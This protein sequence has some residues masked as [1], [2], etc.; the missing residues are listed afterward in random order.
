MSDDIQAERGRLSQAEL[1][2]RLSRDISATEMVTVYWSERIDQH[3]H[4]IYC[5]MIPS[6]RVAESL[7]DPCWDLMHGDGLPG[8]TEYTG[9]KGE[10]CVEYLRFGD[11]HVE[12]LVID[13]EF[14]GI[15]PDYVELSEEFRLFHK[16]Y[17]D[18]KLDQ[19]IKIEDDGSETLVATIEPKRV[20]VR[21]KELRQFL[22]IKEMHLVIQF[23]CREHSIHTLEELGLEAKSEDHFEPTR[24][25]G[26]SYGSFYG[27]GGEHKSFSRLLGKRLIPPLPKEKSGFW[28]FAEPETKEHEHFII[29]V[30]ANGDDVTH[31]SDPD[32]LSNYFGANPGEPHY[33]TAVHFRKS[34]LDKYYQ[35]AGKYTVG[36]SVLWCGRLWS[37][38][39]DNHHDDRVC[40]WLGDL[41]RDLPHSEQLHWRS[42]NIPPVGG[43]SEVYFRRQILAQFTDSTQPEHVFQ[44]RYESLAA[45]C[46]KHSG[47]RLLLPLAAEDQHYLHGIRV[48]ATDEQKDFDDLI[49]GLAK[50]LVD[51]LN[52]AKLSELIA[53]DAAK[54]LRGSIAKLEAA[55]TACGVTD[56]GE[57][58]KFLRNLQNLRSTGSAHRKGSNYQTIAAQ[59]G[60]DSQ[61]LRS[62]FRGILQRT[63][64]LLEY[65]TVVVEAGRLARPEAG[66]PGRPTGSAT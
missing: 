51:S 57:H 34:V 17:H 43:V 30:D 53:P 47:W 10:R 2:A 60:V 61:N 24:C 44:Y 22:A 66:A 48:P 38:Y 15:R 42:Y 21:L 39:I 56:H 62:V 9:E 64:V 32:T 26:L 16:L 31:S 7:K 41:G 23:D 19:F 65:L 36:D 45:A 5:V 46:D 50:V 33:L 6:V 20:Q 11:W 14:H 4:G 13:R 8:A 59:F 12:P 27:M 29:A 52:E 18:R 55:L 63:I 40:A 3:D 35:Q 37:L 49:L 54:G 25:W 1:L 58:T 28:G